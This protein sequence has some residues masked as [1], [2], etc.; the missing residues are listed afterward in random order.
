MEK[1]KLIHGNSDRAGEVRQWLKQ[2]GVTDWNDCPADRDEILYFND[3]G[4]W[5]W[6]PD[7]DVLLRYIDHEIVDLPKPQQEFKPFERVLVRDNE[8]HLW[9]ADIFSHMAVGVFPYCC[10]GGVWSF[11]VP[12]KGNESLL[13][14]TLEPTSQPQPKQDDDENHT[15][16]N[17]VR[18]V[19]VPETADC[20][21]CAFAEMGCHSGSRTPE[22][23]NCSANVRKDGRDIIWVPE[24]EQET[25]TIDES[26]IIINGV[27][28]E[29]VTAPNYGRCD[30]C[31]LLPI[32]Q[33]TCGG[34]SRISDNL[35][36]CS[37]VRDDGR[38]IVWKKHK[39]D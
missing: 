24:Q 15:V 23:K 30:G 33:T 7:G 37:T 10:V 32:G 39:N 5:C 17:G 36:L 26:H 2:Q 11:C 8:K 27:K 38:D 14:T 25:T 35:P 6:C 28:Y 21:G 22:M 34:L 29:A 19:A 12:Y 1:L 16:Y 13:G 3:N 18:Y 9:R 20:V 31:D 4:R